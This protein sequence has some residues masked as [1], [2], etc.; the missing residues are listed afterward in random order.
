MI[1]EVITWHEIGEQ[2]PDADI[3]VLV[4]TDDESEPVWLGWLDEEGWCNVDGSQ[5]EATVK[6]WAH[7][8]T[9]EANA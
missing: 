7:V 9:G 1:R 6:R 5:I 8:P 3:T 2:L 4:C